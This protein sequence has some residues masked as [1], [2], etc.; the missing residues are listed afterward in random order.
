M[1]QASGQETGLRKA[2]KGVL[3]W[4]K[5]RWKSEVHH[6]ETSLSWNEEN[7]SGPS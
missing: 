7:L 4:R 1:L 2:F 5:M 3:V 6:L